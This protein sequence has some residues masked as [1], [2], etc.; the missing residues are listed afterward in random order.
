MGTPR[1]KSRV[2]VLAFFLAVSL[3]HLLSNPTFCVVGVKARSHVRSN[4]SGHEGEV[5]VVG[6]GSYDDRED[7]LDEMAEL[8]E[9]LPED[10]VALQLVAPT[11]DRRRFKVNPAALSVL[12]S[13][14]EPVAIL[15]AV[16]PYHG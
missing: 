3:I 15:A 16:G 5:E 12:E 14:E 13:I 1:S 8:Y 9:A 2:D 4:F 11:D 10:G 6:G 7:S